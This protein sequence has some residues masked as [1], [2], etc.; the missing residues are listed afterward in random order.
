[1]SL[2]STTDIISFKKYL[3]FM[4]KIEMKATFQG[5]L[6]AG[7]RKAPNEIIFRHTRF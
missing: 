7:N 6:V 1:M 2:V 4:G 5:K 3:K